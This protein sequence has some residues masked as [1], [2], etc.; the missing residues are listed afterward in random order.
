M[1]WSQ[2]TRHGACAPHAQVMCLLPITLRRVT[3]SAGS[4]LEG[5]AGTSHH[6]CVRKGRGPRRSGVILP[7]IGRPQP[8]RHSA[9]AQNSKSLRAAPPLQRQRAPARLRRVT[10]S[11][12][13]ALEGAAGTSHHGRVRKERGPRRSVVV[14]PRIGRQPPARHSARAQKDKSLRAA[15]PLQ[16][17]RAQARRCAAGLAALAWR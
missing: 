14:L 2:T 4:A 7:R 5:V 8:A 11:A 16:R 13:L 3:R 10:R 1:H 17:Q 6:G 15:P 12:S 9:R